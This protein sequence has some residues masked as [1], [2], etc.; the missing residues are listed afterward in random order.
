MKENANKASSI[1]LT[2]IPQICQMDWD[3]TLKA[4][5]VSVLSGLRYLGVLSSLLLLLQLPLSQGRPSSLTIGWLMYKAKRLLQIRTL[6]ES[7]LSSAF[8]PLSNS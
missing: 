5:S 6:P 8:L 1:L 2:A 3:T 7:C 4:M